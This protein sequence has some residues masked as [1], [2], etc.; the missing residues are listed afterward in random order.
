MIKKSNTQWSKIQ[1][2]NTYWSNIQSLI[3]RILIDLILN[4]QISSLGNYSNTFPILANSSHF[5]SWNPLRILPNI[6]LEMNI[7]IINLQLQLNLF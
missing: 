3:D 7:F 1:W 2:S 5:K 6:L 4:D